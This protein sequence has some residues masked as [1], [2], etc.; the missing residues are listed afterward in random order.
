[1]A[2]IH[3]STIKF[4]TDISKNN[5]RPWFQEHKGE[6]E[7]AVANVKSFIEEVKK[8]MDKKDHIEG[9]KLFRIYRDVRFAKDKSPYKTNFGIA[10]K[11]ATAKLR[12]GYYLQ[13]QP[14]NSFVGGGFWGPNPADLKRIRKEFEM[15]DKPI[16]KIMSAKPFKAYFGTLM[17]E[18]VKT[19]PK[20]FS[21][22]HPA[23]DLI[24]QMI[25]S[26][27]E[28]HLKSCA[29]HVIVSRI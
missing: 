20:G 19:A 13:I 15:D 25:T 21:V 23:I 26:C 28:N 8:G 22:D 9:M 4:L 6:Y 10:F 11:R 27:F 18:E 24:R 17:G 12:G 29:D 16:R 5:N 3:L 7:T 1:M 2:Q 14:D